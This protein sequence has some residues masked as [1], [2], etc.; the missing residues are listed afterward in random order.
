M[1]KALQ[2]DLWAMIEGTKTVLEK[3]NFKGGLGGRIGRSEVIL[4][5]TR[6]DDGE[7]FLEKAECGRVYKVNWSVWKD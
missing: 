1:P 6:S 4:V 2:D 5:H 3:R 7:S